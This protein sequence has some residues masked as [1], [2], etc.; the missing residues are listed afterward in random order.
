MHLIEVVTEQGYQDTVQ[1]LAEQRQ[2]IDSWVLQADET[3]GRVCVRILV[4]D[5]CTQALLDGLQKVLG[6]SEG[7]R[8]LLLPVEAVLPRPAGEVA[9]QE[10]SKTTREE[11]IE[12]ME[13]SARLDLSFLGLVAL[14]SVVAAVGL[15]SDNVAVVI[16]AMLIAPLL[17][18]NLALALATAIGDHHLAATALRTIFTGLLL[19]IAIAFVVGL[20]WSTPLGSL[21]VLAR[22]DVGLDG[23]A[24]ALASGAAAA[25]SM[26]TGVSSVLVGVMVAVALLPPATVLGLL[27]GT[28]QWPLALG[29]G[30]LLAV[31]VVSVNLAAK[32]VFAWRGVRPRTWME[33]QRA[34]RSLMAFIVFWLISLLILLGAVALRHVLMAN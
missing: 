33:R 15:I 11:L 18:P 23:V 6:A 8:I 21:E 22:T 26:T 28:G 5:E 3:G 24:L 7:S 34:R 27:L 1:G 9:A 2:V 14:S 30:L 17:G 10:A 13:R 32:L 20:M 29:A 19:A 25:L 4:T 12:E 31:N 16:G